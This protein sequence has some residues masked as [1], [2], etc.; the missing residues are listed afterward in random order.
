MASSTTLKQLVSDLLEETGL[1]CVLPSVTG[2][3]SQLT[4][5]NAYAAGPFLA[6]KFTRGS[7]IMV[8][9]GGTVGDNT[10]VDT[11]TASSGVITVTPSIT[12]GATDAVLAYFGTGID[13]MD[14][15]RE[16]INRAL[17]RKCKRL[18]RVAATMNGTTSGGDLRSTTWTE[19]NCTSGYNDTLNGD[20]DIDR[21]IDIVATSTNAYIYSSNV[22]V[23][24]GD[25]W[26]FQVIMASYAAG[27]TARITFYDNENATTITPTFTSGSA[28]TTN[29]SYVVV[30]G[31][32]TIPTGCSFMQVRLGVDESGG[33]A[34]FGPVMLAP[35][36]TKYYPAGPWLR[37][38][39]DIG[40]LWT[41]RYPYS[42]SSPPV[43]A[44]SEWVPW[45]G[46][47]S[48][49]NFAGA[50]VFNFIDT[51]PFPLF[52]E[53]WVPGDELTAVTSETQFPSEYVLMWAKYELRKMLYEREQDPE[54]KRMAKTLALEAKKSADCYEFNTTDLTVVAGRR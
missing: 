52:Y 26:N 54:K 13:H 11:Y 39:S 31:T 50:P 53:A 34:G 14:R 32:V 5:S 40:N 7:P 10:Y 15:V 48:I 19:S 37:S 20:S 4:L 6:Q 51:P 43:A 38:A 46:R 30:A 2:T 21:T 28:T 9:A 25:V 47:Y 22:L 17:T 45:E 18:V 41:V 24:A 23:N 1:G 44:D 49:Q 27:S 8:T 42:T 16:A 29:K 3:T 12:T 36:G 35:Q 33:R